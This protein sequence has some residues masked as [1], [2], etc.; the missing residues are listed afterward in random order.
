MTRPKAAIQLIGAINPDQFYPTTQSVP[1]FGTGWQSTQDKVESGELPRPF[2]LTPGSNRK[3][4]LG[5]QI[6]E[7]RARMQ[8]LAEQQAVVD[9]AKPKQAQP[10]GFKRKIKKTKLRTDQTLKKRA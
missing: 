1:I 5:S 2:P 4:W 6:L 9:S 3:G 8:A 7:H 10:A